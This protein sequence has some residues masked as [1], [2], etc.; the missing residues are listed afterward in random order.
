MEGN[1]MNA[2]SELPSRS[3][4]DIEEL[5]F[6]LGSVFA[7]RAPELDRSGSFVHANYQDLKEAR[8]F[9]LG[10]P[11]ALG[12]G[13]LRYAELAAACRLLARHCGST[14]LAYA[15]HSH[16][17]ALNVFKYVRGDERATHTLKKLAAEEL[18]ICGTGASDWLASNGS[19]TA[20][21]GGYRVN[22]RKRFV[23][24]SP[25]A[26]LLVTSVHCAQGDSAE[27]LHFAVPMNAPGI[28][29]QSNW[30]TLGMRATGSNDVLLQDVFVA[31]AAIVAR[32]PAG[33]WHG[34]WDAILPNAMPLIM[35]V[36]LGLADAAKDYAI[37]AAAGDAAQAVALGE[38][39]NQH[40]LAEI[41]VAD[42]IARHDEYGFT[43][44]PANTSAILTRK[45]LATAAIQKTVE[46]ACNIVGGKA[47]FKTHPLERIARDVRAAHFHP[48]PQD[49]QLP[50]SGR[51]LAGLDP[52]A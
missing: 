38:L 3:F 25:A 10:V 19:A 50:F 37:E 47:F 46:L 42:M 48:L 20:V 33:Q 24:G 12:G 26:N 30:D 11:A 1:T 4:T 36:Y 39:G 23:S 40:T 44:S 43:P 52:V 14:A 21:E 17:L 35:S 27:V 9:S 22:A 32:R 8:F 2:Y 51:V 6:N 7:A 16:P 15:M 41:A 18:I 31:D 49:K 29:Q 13:G 28:Q 34:I 45:T 5:A